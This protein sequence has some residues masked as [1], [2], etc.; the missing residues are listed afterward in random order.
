MTAALHRWLISTRDTDAIAVSLVP[1]ICL[2]AAL[3]V[4]NDKI[5]APAPLTLH[6]FIVAAILYCFR[7]ENALK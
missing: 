4:Y 5:C 2:I 1:D 7:K 3:L 6:L